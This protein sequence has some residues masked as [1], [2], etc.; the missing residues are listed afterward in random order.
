[1]VLRSHEQGVGP[2]SGAAGFEDLYRR[3][4]GGMLALA[5]ATVRNRSLAEDLVQDAY[6]H[7]TRTD[8]C[9]RSGRP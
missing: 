1:M 3:T 7:R 9:G 8:S 5:I 2:D 4:C 6:G